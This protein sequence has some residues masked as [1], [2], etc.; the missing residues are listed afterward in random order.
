MRK[1]IAAAAATV[2]RKGIE[3]ID[4]DKDDGRL[5]EGW[6]AFCPH[7]YTP[8]GY[9]LVAEQDHPADE[10]APARFPC[11]VKTCPIDSFIDP[12]EACNWNTKD[13][14]FRHPHCPCLTWYRPEY[15]DGVRP[16]GADVHVMVTARECARRYRTLGGR[17][18]PTTKFHCWRCG[19]MK[20]GDSWHCT[21]H[22]TD[23]CQSCV[24]ST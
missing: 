16:P 4:A 23:Y 1:E 9:G 10:S 6:G 19:I 18:Q 2:E 12:F 24:R 13:T 14:N 17:G 5:D 11:T 20:T 15:D 3:R 8:R 21:Y 7:R 22:Q